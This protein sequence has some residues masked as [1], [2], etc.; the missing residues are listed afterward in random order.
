MN[1]ITG[2]ELGIFFFF[3]SFFF[4]KPG[5]LPPQGTPPLVGKSPCQAG[6][7]VGEA[8]GW[9]RAWRELGILKEL[10]QVIL[11]MS[12][13]VVCVPIPILQMS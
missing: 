2:F 9:G 6:G 11:L 1:G 8:P 12:L 4:F 5:A 10:T 7:G 13:L 3:L